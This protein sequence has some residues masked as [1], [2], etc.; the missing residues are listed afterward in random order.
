MVMIMESVKIRRKNIL[1]GSDFS[2]AQQEPRL[3]ANYAKD[4]N[5]INAY[6]EGKDLYATMAT[7]VYHTPYE[8]NK[9]FYPDG[10]MNPEGK[11]RRTTM[12]RLLLG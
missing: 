8:Q 12:K 9:E 11:H 10:T 2:Q 1:V 5:M 7:Q 4:D 3:L 6:K